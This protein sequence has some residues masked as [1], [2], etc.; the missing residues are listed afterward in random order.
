MAEAQVVGTLLTGYHLPT[1]IYRGVAGW[2]SGNRMRLGL[3]PNCV[4]PARTA[5]SALT[6][7]RLNSTGGSWTCWENRTGWK[8]PATADR[9]GDERPIPGRGESLIAPWFMERTKQEILE[10]CLEHRIPC[11][12]VQTFD[13]ALTDPQLNAR[14]YFQPMGHTEAGGYNYPGPPYRLSGTPARLMRSAPTLGQHNR[15]VLGGEL[16]LDASEIAKL[17]QEGIV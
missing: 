17:E 1:Y 5:I 6:P 3:F 12:P 4:L 11:V 2:R 15:E 14:D 7:H 13:E 10:A 8:T 9:A 16:G